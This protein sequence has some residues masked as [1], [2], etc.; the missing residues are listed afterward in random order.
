MDLG[1]KT[2]EDALHSLDLE[3]LRRMLL[4]PPENWIDGELANGFWVEDGKG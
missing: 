1:M 2:Y 4:H 3:D